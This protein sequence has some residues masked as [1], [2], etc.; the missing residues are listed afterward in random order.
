MKLGDVPP[1]RTARAYC[2]CPRNRLNVRHHDGTASWRSGDAA[3]CQSVYT[4]SIPVL[5]SITTFPI[6]FLQ[7]GQIR[8]TDFIGKLDC[9]PSSGTRLIVGSQLVW[10]SNVGILGN[11]DTHTLAGQIPMP[12]TDVACHGAKP[13]PT[14][15]PRK[16]TMFYGLYRLSYHPRTPWVGVNGT[17]RKR[18]GAAERTGMSC[19][20][21]KAK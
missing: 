1:D 11:T 20:G 4:G 10:V 17:Q 14:G 12:L 13:D 3:D 15:K 8:S 7:S 2:A 19:L 9:R 5:A 18:P 6:D 16:S 21:R